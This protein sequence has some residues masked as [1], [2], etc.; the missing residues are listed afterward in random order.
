MRTRKIGSLTTFNLAFISIFEKMMGLLKTL[1]FSFFYGTSNISDAF[2]I[3]LTIPDTFYSLFANG[4]NSSYIPLISSLKNS[5][6]KKEFNSKILCFLIIVTGTISVVSIPL[7]GFMVSIFA[8]GFDLETYELT[9]FLVQLC[10]FSILFTSISNLLISFLQ[11]KKVFLLPSLTPLFLNIFQCAGIMISFFSGYYWLSI[12]I[13]FGSFFQMCFLSIVS[14]KNGFSFKLII[15]DK[16]TLKSIIIFSLPIF[17]SASANRINVIVDKAIASNFGYGNV[18]SLSYA[19]SLTLFVKTIFAVPIITT[20]FPLFSSHVADNNTCQLKNDA[21]SAFERITF[22]VLP[23]TL[24]VMLL[25][26]AIVTIVFQRGAFDSNSTKMTSECLT[27]YIIGLPAYCYRDLIVK[28]FYAHKNSRIPTINLIIGLVLNIF[29]NFVFST[30]F[31]V[32][33]LALATSVSAYITFLLLAIQLKTKLGINLFASYSRLLRFIFASLIMIVA[34]ALSALCFNI[35]NLLLLTFVVVTI[36]IF[37]YGLSL[38]I[39]RVYTFR[40]LIRRFLMK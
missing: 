13:L 18:S 3:T 4:I 21:I 26:E 10:V 2:N 15:P 32:K 35:S 30:F 16:K 1:L 7:S 22:Y 31:G 27:Y 34:V 23:I 19:D 29:L 14:Y 11:T 36:G 28:M 20:F 12:G 25:S 8:P 17:L 24:G 33:G 40:D 38:V 9:S 37:V 39:M 6:Q 5:E